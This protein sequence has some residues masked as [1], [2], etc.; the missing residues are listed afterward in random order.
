[1]TATRSNFSELIE[2]GLKSIYGMNYDQW[3]PEYDRM[4]DMETSNQA[5]EEYQEITGF[6]LVP[7]KTEQQPT[8]Y[9][10]AIQGYKKTLTNI[11]YSLGFKITSEMYE[12]DLYRQMNNMPKSLALSVAQTVE[13]LGALI[14]DRAFNSAYLGADGVSLCSTAHP[15]PGGGTYSNRPVEDADLSMTSYESAMIDIAA[16]KDGRNKKMHAKPIRLIVTETFRATA[17]R[18]LQS[19]GDPDTAE[20]SINPFQNSVD[21]MVTHY[22]SDPDAW[23]IR[24]S[25]PGLICQKRKWPADMRKD[26]DFDEDVAKFKTSFRLVYG[27]YDS[28]ALYG[29]A[30]A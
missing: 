25:V 23:F 29:S 8:T 22:T 27:W 18:I 14:Y 24:T 10:D 12:D 2:P 9:D 6:G 5:S 17:E 28:R 26:N 20:R 1:M 19:S 7:V 4:F 16:F 30:G 3:K 15:L 21:Y 13:T 11:T